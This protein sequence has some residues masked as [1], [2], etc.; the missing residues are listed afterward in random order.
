MTSA[1]VCKDIRKSY[2]GLQVLQGVDL[3]VSKGEILG[4][5]GAN[6]AGKTTLIDVIC[7]QQE[8]NAGS[9]SIGATRIRGTPHLRARQG[10]ARTFQAPQFAPELSV[11]QNMLVGLAAAKL[12]SFTR[13]IVEIGMAA[14]GFA[15][16]EVAKADEVAEKLSLSGID[17]AARDVTFGELRLMEIGRAI[18]QDPEVMILDEPFSGVGDAGLKA[19]TEALRAVR[20]QGAA[21]MI[22]DHNVDLLT[23][24]VDRMALL[25]AGRI[26]VDGPVET[27]LTSDVFRKTYIGVV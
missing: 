18:L 4:L 21:V 25:A 11:R 3:S 13:C 23:S 20:T 2:G 24:V 16:S 22:I 8:A 10:L 9:A 12:R 19:I 7:G 14:L 26:V 17:R 6:G 5:V 1:L 27:C 15:K